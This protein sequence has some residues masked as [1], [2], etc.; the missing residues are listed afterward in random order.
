MFFEPRRYRKEKAI[1]IHRAP[2]TRALSALV[3]AVSLSFSTQAS[4][5]K[6]SKSGLCHPPKSNWYDRTKNYQAYDSLESCLDAGGELPQG[7]PFAALNAQQERSNRP[8]DYDRS[9]FGHGWS[10]SDRDCQD[11]RAEALIATSTTPVEFASDKRCRVVRGR[12]I[13]PFTN[14]VIQNASDI[15]IDHVVPL[16][17]AWHRGANQWTKR[18]RERFA[19]DGI[20]LWPVEASLNRSKGA[21][22]PD[23]WLPPSGQCGYVARFAR[24]TMKYKLQQREA[25][26]TWIEE[27]LKSCRN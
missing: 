15:D 21:Q 9:K 23:Q 25:E 18:D 2:K 6:M 13:S 4:P 24:I 20:N 16:A 19:N 3:I 8:Q 1:A 14:Q 12:W 17:W 11:S 5:V 7:I 22:G 27:F 10:D 26:V